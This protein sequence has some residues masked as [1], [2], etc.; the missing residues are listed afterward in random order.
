MVEKQR[1]IYIH[2]STIYIFVHCTLSVSVSDYTLQ[3]DQIP[4][5]NDSTPETIKQFFEDLGEKMTPARKITVEKVV[6]AY[7][8]KQL[9]TLSENLNSQLVNKYRQYMCLLS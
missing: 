2:F 7:D 6:L 5:S 1:R 3:V 9:Q 4:K 8:I